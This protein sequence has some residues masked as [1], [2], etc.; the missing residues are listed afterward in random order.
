MVPSSVSIMH[1][2]NSYKECVPIR[3]EYPIGIICTFRSRWDCF[4]LKIPLWTY[5]I[6]IKS[7]VALCMREGFDWRTQSEQITDISSTINL[8]NTLPCRWIISIFN[9]DPNASLSMSQHAS[10]ASAFSVAVSSWSY[11]A[12]FL[13]TAFN[14][15]WRKL[16]GTMRAQIIE[17]QV[18]DLPAILEAVCCNP[19]KDI[20][21]N[22]E[23]TNHWYHHQ[24]RQKS[25]FC[26]LK[27]FV[28][29]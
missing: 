4:T 28:S 18:A 26:F 12:H 6:Y 19:P 1:G 9:Q 27:F 5:V 7:I 15:S 2:S 23:Y 10:L 14:L 29:C 17:I 3:A 24:S 25:T 8:N 20:A 22:N 16:G 13:P 11:P 21:S